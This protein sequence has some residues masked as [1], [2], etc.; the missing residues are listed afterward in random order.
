MDIHELTR[1]WHTARIALDDPS[2]YERLCWAAREYHK[3]HPEVSETR[4]YKELS[5]SLN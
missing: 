3:A 2:R 1:L 5:N 4:A